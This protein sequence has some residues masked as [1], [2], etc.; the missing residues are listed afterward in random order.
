MQGM[1]LR[2]CLFSLA[3]LV[4]TAA[5]ADS[6]MSYGGNDDLAYGHGEAGNAGEHAAADRSRAGSGEVAPSG[7]QRSTSPRDAASPGSGSGEP[8]RQAQT[9]WNDQEF[10]RNVWSTP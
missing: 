4:A 8:A 3:M 1:K 7:S 10:L 9:N 6:A 2:S 5:R